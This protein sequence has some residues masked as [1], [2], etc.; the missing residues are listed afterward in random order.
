MTVYKN[1]KLNDVSIVSRQD[2]VKA[3]EPKHGFGEKQALIPVTRDGKTF[4]RKQKVGRKGSRY[5]DNHEDAV[6]QKNVDVAREFLKEQYPNKYLSNDEID[7][8]AMKFIPENVKHETGQFMLPDITYAIVEANKKNAQ[9]F[10]KDFI[11]EKTG[12]PKVKSHYT[13]KME[14]DETSDK[15]YYP[16]TLVTENEIRSAYAGL[17]KDIGALANIYAQHVNSYEKVQEKK[18]VAPIAKL[19]DEEY[20]KRFKTSIAQLNELLEQEIG[21]KFNLKIDFE[22]DRHGMLKGYLKDQNVYSEKDLGIM[23]TVIKSAAFYM[24]FSRSTSQNTVWSS[25]KLGWE[26][27]GMG[28]NG[29]DVFGKDGKEIYVIYD[30][31]SNE[32]SRIKK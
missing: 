22:K 25:L 10:I 3:E 12:V 9:E 7:Q 27:H 15:R 2:V 20:E 29:S 19:S 17:P 16:E 4:F 26:H 30:Q 11:Y 32:W 31:I 8:I 24:Y 18:K 14:W 28:T 5:Q 23:S 1:G 13:G 6:D 21:L